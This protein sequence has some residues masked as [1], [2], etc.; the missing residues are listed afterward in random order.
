MTLTGMDLEEHLRDPAR[1]QAYVTTMFDIIAPRYDAF[2]RIFSYGMDK[3]WKR[4][5]ID[6][7][8]ARV[9]E[10]AAI[11]DLA[12]GTGDIAIALASARPLARIEGLDA[13][14]R[15]I[16]LARGA[17]AAKAPAV[18]LRVGD[19]MALPYGDGE[20]DAIT[21]GYGL[22]NVPDFRGALAE[23]ARVL[24]PGGVLGCLDFSRPENWAWR[25]VF[26]G[27]LAIAGSV[28]GWWWHREPDVY[29]YIG[30][31]IDRFVSY[32]DLSRA[33]R[34]VGLEPSV[35]RPR[36][37]GGVCLHVCRKSRK[38]DVRRPTSGGQGLARSLPGGVRTSDFVLRTF[39]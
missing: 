26:L 5:L 36:L 24:K 14:E 1:K 9:P 21:I 25:D 17:C 22:R 7:V 28:V 39:R 37:H 30:R 20:L 13:S 32:S 31:S 33:M 23:C 8:V 29:R 4:E 11:V 18:T 27:Y 19:M 10:R 15:M 12:C 3:R 35:V 16:E 2:T 6:E 34:E 38:H